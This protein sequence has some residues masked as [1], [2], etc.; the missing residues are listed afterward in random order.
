MS[1]KMYRHRRSGKSREAASRTVPILR[2]ATYEG[3]I[4]ATIRTGEQPRLPSQRK[5]AQRSLGC[6]VGHADLSVMD[7]ACKAVPPLE[8]IVDWLDHVGRARQL[9]ALRLQPGLKIAQ[10]RRTSLLADPQPFLVAQSVDLAL[11]L[12]QLVN[13]TNRFQRNGRDRRRRSSAARVLG[14]IGQFRGGLR[15]R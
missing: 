3:V 13:P 5:T 15:I 10:Q 11:D 6:I 4:G 8:Q 2:E 9:G 1:L 14:D 12:E 7:E